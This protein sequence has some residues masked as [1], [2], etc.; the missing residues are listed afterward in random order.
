[1]RD[2]ASIRSR[3]LDYCAGKPWADCQY[4]GGM[5][6]GDNWLTLDELAAHKVILA[7]KHRRPKGWI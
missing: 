5:M 7:S 1:M 3:V 2:G 6:H 4:G